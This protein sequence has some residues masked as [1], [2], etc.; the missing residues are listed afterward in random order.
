VGNELHISPRDKVRRNEIELRMHSQLV[1][2]RAVADLAHQASEVR[3]TGFD[4]AQGK[5]V[6][7]SGSGAALGP[8]TG[9]TGKALLVPA[10]GERTQQSAHRLALSQSEARALAEAEFAARARR[11][12]RVEGVCQG[13]PE[14][15][16]GSHVKL[17]DVSPRFDNCYY[18]T[19]CVHRY[20]EQRGYTT[21]FSAE[22]A[23]LGN[24]GS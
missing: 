17:A 20:D 24:P 5:A 3:V 19:G 9:R 4:P 2:V 23:Y 13:N 7:A 12:V 22:G 10:F 8:G 21:E 18:V 6:Q 11:F 15:R 1:R 14:L 16:V